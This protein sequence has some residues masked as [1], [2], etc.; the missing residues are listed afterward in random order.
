MLYMVI[1]TFRPEELN[2]IYARLKKNGRMMPKGLEYIDSWVAVDRSR[3][4]QLMKAADENSL[5]TWMKYWKDLVDF[6]VVPV[7]PSSEM[8]KIASADNK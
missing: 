6:K 8:Q 2:T 3:C 4:F 5:R 7:I 1:E